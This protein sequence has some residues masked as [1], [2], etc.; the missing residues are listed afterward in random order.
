M[1]KHSPPKKRRPT[2]PTSRRVIKIKTFDDLLAREQE[3][4]Q[5]IN[6]TPNGGRLLLLDPL[7][8]LRDVDVHL[9]DVAIAEWMR[10]AG[11]N[12]FSIAGDGS[13]YDAVARINPTHGGGT[14]RVHGLVQRRSAQP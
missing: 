8:L 5:R 6:A 2:P 11:D 10:A 4:V 13:A 12:I 3:L 9:T 14:V 7:R 1:V